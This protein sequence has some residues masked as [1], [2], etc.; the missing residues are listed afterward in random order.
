MAGTAAI[1]LAGTGW[2]LALGDEGLGAGARIEEAIYR[3][4]SVNTLS[5][6][7]TRPIDEIGPGEPFAATLLL[8][9]RWLGAVVF[10]MTLFKVV[11]SLFL[12]NI[13]AFICKSTWRDHVVVIGGREFAHE[14]AEAAAQ[15]GESVVHFY[16]GGKETV[17]DGILSLD[18]GI[19][20]EAIL[21]TSAAHRARSLVFAADDNANS[22]DMATAVFNSAEFDRAARRESTEKLPGNAARRGPHI[23]VCVDD[24][25]FEHREELEY[26]VHKVVPYG[27]Q[28]EDG[29]LD[30]VVELISESR[31]AA[32]SVLS[33]HPVF[34]LSERRRQHI[35]LV[36][37][38]AV[39]EALLTEICETQ[40]IDPD[41]PHMFTII[42][43]DG[44]S[45]ARF[46][47]RCPEWTDV[48]D[49]VHLDVDL[50]D[51]GSDIS[52]LTARLA[53]APPTAAYVATG[54]MTDPAILA[55]RL[56]QSVAQMTDEGALNEE[57]IRFPIFTC[58]RGSRETAHGHDR[59][60][61]DSSAILS[62]MPVIAFGAWR[63]IV[64][65]ARILEKEP[66][67][68]AFAVHAVHNELYSDTPP[69]NWSHVAEVNR[70]SSRSAAA[71]VPALIH[72][73]GFNLAPWLAHHAPAPP[74][75][76][77]LPAPPPGRSLAED[78]S[79]LVY[80]ARL[81]HLRWC[82][83]RRLRG[84]R[85]AAKKDVARRRHPDLVAFD[86]LPQPSQIYNLRYIAEL[87]NTLAESKTQ[88][89]APPRED[90]PRVLVR[91]T[92]LK[93]L[94]AAGLITV[95]PARHETKEPADADS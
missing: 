1:L 19:G 75:V 90:A 16:P 61:S 2:W 37:F 12:E 65:A 80:L 25:W 33:A 8:I 70:Y 73:A 53:A 82:A 11:I 23:Y 66:D 85:H 49:G 22:L 27:E 92:D 26:S 95:A 71:F 78:T 46:T 84:F 41:R 60:A 87:S 88:L 24:A 3:A 89:Y 29:A 48:F 79:E 18:S 14:V 20:L 58:V 72:A 17:A 83:E 63:D 52:H 67:R 57:D 94:E 4:L 9:A 56:K 31:C 64:L 62:R 6:S 47:Q 35:V 74:S 13:L 50:Q 38:G 28:A 15:A 86:T 39:G 93:L 32:R 77:D 76:N 51:P 81:E 45:W 36:G 40:R 44:A 68:A 54:D 91:P 5:E 30:S 69:T 34:T 21:E 43:P 10:F 7:Y 55:A 42:D 59:L